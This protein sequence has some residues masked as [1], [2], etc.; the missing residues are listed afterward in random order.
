LEEAGLAARQEVGNGQPPRWSPTDPPRDDTLDNLKL[1]GPHDLR[2]T[3]STWLED[4]GIPARVI[5][6][7]MGHAGG[8]RGGRE[9][10]AIGLRY[11]HTTPDMEGRVV[12]AIEQ[13]LAASL[14]VAARV[15]R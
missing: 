6:E 3:F 1:R 2:H 8:D 13:R 14:A 15:S 9:G 11:R 4:A 7:L 5:D 12:A 10:S